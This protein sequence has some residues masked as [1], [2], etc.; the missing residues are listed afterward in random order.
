MHL[1]VGKLHLIPAASLMLSRNSD[2]SNFNYVIKIINLLINL[3]QKDWV[4]DHE[5][6]LLI[7]NN[8]HVDVAW[9]L[10]H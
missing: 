7:Y 8:S 1:Y 5:F 10:G 4:G 3:I 6:Q 9:L 2:V